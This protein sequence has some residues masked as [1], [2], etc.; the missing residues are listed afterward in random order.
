MLHNVVEYSS[1]YLSIIF[2]KDNLFLINTHM[3]L[4]LQVLENT[5]MLLDLKEDPREIIS[6]FLDSSHHTLQADIDAGMPL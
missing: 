1:V 4:M 3:F 2:I 6:L 5:N